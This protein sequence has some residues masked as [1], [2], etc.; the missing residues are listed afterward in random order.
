MPDVELVAV[1]D[2]DEKNAQTIARRHKTKAYSDY[3]EILGLVDAV[4]IASPTQTHFEISRDFLKEK[5]HV[6][7][8]KP[9]TRTLEQA[10]ELVRLAKENE[11]KLQ[12]GHV[13]RFNPAVMEIASRNLQPVFI[14]ALR[15]SPFRF[16]SGDIGVVLDLMIHDIDI[17]RSLVRSEVE[18]VDAVGVNLLGKNEDIANA[19]VTFKC[20]CVANVTASRA[21]LKSVRQVR[22]F[23]PDTYVSL[24]YG[25][26]KGVLIKKP[27]EVDFESLN[28]QQSS[29]SSFFG[30]TFEEIFF[31]KIMQIEKL[32]MK[33][34][35]PLYKELENFISSIVND[36]TPMVPGEDGLEAMRVAQMILQDIGKNLERAKDRFRDTKF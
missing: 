31:G 17:I 16:R 1:V 13:E 23:S 36:V 8:E 14:E 7:V 6:L 22:I 12:V 18:K 19:R 3:K 15:L 10:E 28:L 35:E 21:S 33:A 30:R 4:S 29:A 25:T 20:G 27:P 34:H 5:V 11:V 32:S 2:N 9:M 24:D 26:M